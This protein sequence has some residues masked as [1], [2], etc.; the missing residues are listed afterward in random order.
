MPQR[1]LMWFFVFGPSVWFCVAASADDADWPQWRGPQSSGVARD[2]KFPAVWPAGPLA[3]LWTAPTA[4][5]WSSP[6]VADGRVFVTDRDDVSERV[7]AFDAATGR[8]LW[9]VTNP[10]DFDPH[11]VGRRHGNGP[12][13]TPAVSGDKVYAL[14]IAGW[15]QCLNAAD[16]AVVWKHVLPAEYADSQPLPGGR[17][18]VNGETNVIVPIG[19]ARGAPVPLFGYTGSLVVAGDLLIAPVGGTRG[20][21]IM[22]FDKHSGRVVWQALNENVSY[23]SPIV[24]DLAGLRQVVAMTGPRVVGLDVR[25]GR[26]LWSFDY[27]VQYDE[28]IGTP[29]VADDLVLVTAVGR[30]LSAHRIV[31]ENGAFRAAEAWRNDDLSSY[32]SSMLAVG[33]HVY[34]MNDGGE[35]HC[36]RLSDGNTVWRGGNHGYY[37]T[38]VLVD[39]RLLGLNERGELDVVA[40]DPT[41]YRNLLQ[42]RLTSEATWTSPAVVGNR[43]YVRSRTSLICFEVR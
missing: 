8:L 5:G 10:V 36:L 21:T 42:R 27:Q 26:L 37:S 11:Q 1:N 14:G 33:G 24:V 22:A 20:G 34:G 23:S 31:A 39:N 29:V 9:R 18:Y 6:V 41:A 3:P 30:P 13:S 17:A 7:A 19:D 4:D 38:P 35:W 32:L 12:K 43:L 16:G 2:T 25:D 15:L 28:S 40:A